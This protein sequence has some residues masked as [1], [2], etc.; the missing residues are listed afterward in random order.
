MEDGSLPSEEQLRKLVKENRTKFTCEDGT[1][2][3]LRGEK[4]LA[5]VPFVFRTDLIWK[6]HIGLGHL[7]YKAILDN[8]NESVW[9]P[10][11][12]N[13]VQK[14]IRTCIQC[15]KVSNLDHTVK[16]GLHQLVAV[17]PFHR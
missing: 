8:L 10:D 16:E 5:Y 14:T 9:F 13:F 17:P 6:T 15:Q 2:F 3:R 7:G 12:E 1:L 4:R 11:I